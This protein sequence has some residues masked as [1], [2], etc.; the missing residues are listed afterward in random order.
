MFRLSVFL[1]AKQQSDIATQAIIIKWMCAS[2]CVSE[3]ATLAVPPAVAPTW[4]HGVPGCQWGGLPAQP[5]E[6]MPI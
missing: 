2:A 1:N 3:P 5:Q 6:D 4:S